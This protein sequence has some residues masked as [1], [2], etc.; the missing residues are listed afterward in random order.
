MPLAIELAA[1]RV[2]VLDVE[3][4][5]E[6]LEQDSRLLRHAGR[7]TPARHQTLYE[8]LEWSHRMLSTTE[9]TLFRRLAA[10]RGTF[11]LPGRRGRWCLH[12]R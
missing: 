6:R 3:Q 9:Q 10:F 12:R 8:T 1:A 2:P 4:I 5:A 7:S 11:S